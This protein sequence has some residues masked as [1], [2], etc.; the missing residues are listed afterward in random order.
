MRTY[1]VASA[2]LAAALSGCGL[3]TESSVGKADPAADAQQPW[4]QPV[5]KATCGPTDRVEPALQGQVPAPIRA[6]GFHGNNC[7]LELVGQWQGD[8]AG[9]QHAWFE[10]CAYYGT[11]VREGRA[12]PG[13]VVIDASQR[14]NPH[15][16]AYLTEK[17]MLDPW[18]S[19]KV[20]EQRQLLGADDGNDGG[21]GNLVSIYDIS[22]D[23]R[24][25]VLLASAP[26]GEDTSGHEGNWM[27]DGNT[28]WS[29]NGTYNAMDTSDPRKPEYIMS[30]T[31]PA[32]T[33]GLAFSKD[34]MRGFFT[35]N[36][37]T[38]VVPGTEPTNGFV[39][40]D[41]SDIQLRKPDPEIRV[42][43]RV[44]WV[45]GST[46]QH[47][48]PVKI[49]GKPYVIYVDELGS[50][51]AGADGPM[52]ASCAQGLPP[53]GM[54]RMFDI[55]DEANPKLVA[56]F[57]LETN[58]PANCPLV[59]PDVVG[60]VIFSY[61]SH[62]C[63]VDD[64]EDATAMACGFFNSG[65]RVFDIRNP[66]FPREIA[67]FNPPAQLAKQGKLPGSQHDSFYLTHTGGVLDADWCSSQSRF[68]PD[69]GELWVTCQDNGFM[70][71]KFT[72]GTW[73][74]KEGA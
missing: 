56:K 22:G 26:M 24:Q 10:D 52:A 32:G 72:N 9:W 28:Y 54:P 4:E 74:F 11:T 43:S 8:G 59:M 34:G 2:A 71:L 66:Y 17:P 65:I 36:S 42:I 19:L 25:P 30:W 73:P 23:C 37:I 12:N 44:A 53:W 18:E 41:T 14:S 40:A 16:T 47:P 51:F 6:Q 48:I 60:Q 33:H 3:V 68:V 50:E 7:N 62:Y 64:D 67:Y 46:G 35:T 69:R 63:S 20:N 55:S 61:D 49:G 38:P 58:D 1:L 29:A 13:T 70:I 57:M 45:D 21:G 27:V 15:P 5:R 39:I 31:P